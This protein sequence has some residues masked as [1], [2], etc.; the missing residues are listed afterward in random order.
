MALAARHRGCLLTLSILLG[1]GARTSAA[2]AYDGTDVTEA[3]DSPPDGNAGAPDGNAGA[4]DAPAYWVELCSP[5]DSLGS[6]RPA[7]SPSLPS[8]LRCPPATVVRAGPVFEIN[9]TTG[10]TR[11]CY[12]VPGGVCVDG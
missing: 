12:E 3:V 2:D 9:T 6:C 7:T 4:S 8:A 11:C 1:C 10:V 5:V